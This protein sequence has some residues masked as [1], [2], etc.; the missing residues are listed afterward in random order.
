MCVCVC[1][2]VC[3]NECAFSTAPNEQKVTQDQFLE[4]SL[5]GLNL[6]FSFSLMGCHT[7]LKFASLPY[8]L[9]IVRG[10]I[11]GFVL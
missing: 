6:K 3:V 1:V 8:Y 2:C 7:K 10:K 9:P 11:V 5:T 4:Q